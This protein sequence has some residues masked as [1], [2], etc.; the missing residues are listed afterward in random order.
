MKNIVRSGTRIS[1]GG[2]AT[3]W[4][5]LWVALL[6][7]ALLTGCGGTKVYEATKTVLYRGS[8]YNLS[9]TQAVKRSVTGKLQNDEVV[10]LSGTDK[11]AFGSLVKENGPV[12]VR[13]SFLFD[14]EEMP[15]RADT[16]KSWSEFT[17]MKKDFDR[18]GDKLAK[19]MKEQKSSQ[20][21]LR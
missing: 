16:I 5:G 4:R 15:Y 11:R 3:P 17:R 13:M 21:E 1:S 6:G 18:A 19:L 2:F 7:A 20:I 14:A 12:Y 8:I 9:E 10:D